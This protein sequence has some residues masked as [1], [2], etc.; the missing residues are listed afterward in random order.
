[1]NT[2]PP[3]PVTPP[4]INFQDIPERGQ[5]IHLQYLTEHTGLR[6]RWT[7]RINSHLDYAH[8]GV[9]VWSVA[10]FRWNTLW[11]LLPEHHEVASPFLPDR[12]AQ[13]ASWQGLLDELANKA[14]FIL[15]R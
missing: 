13:A 3:Q 8:Y 9:E 14:A 2:S 6:L 15:A 7:L 5:V 10:N 1:M 4:T 12:K 11:E